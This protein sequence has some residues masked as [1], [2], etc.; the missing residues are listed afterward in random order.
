M[1]AQKITNKEILDNLK[2]GISNRSIYRIKQY[3][4]KLTI[5]YDV[6]G[7]GCLIADNINEYMHLNYPEQD[8]SI[9]I[10]HILKNYRVE[11]NLS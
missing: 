4:D 5:Y 10:P 1:T 6:R 11:V 3:S 7:Q 2:K 9:S 8:Y